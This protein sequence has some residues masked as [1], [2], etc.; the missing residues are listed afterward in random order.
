MT[1]RIC[2]VLN[3]GRKHLAR[4]WCNHHYRRWQK[5]GDVQADTP[6]RGSGSDE[7][8]FLSRLERVPGGCWLWS[9]AT[10]SNGYGVIRVGGPG[11]G[12]LTLAHVWSYEHF[13]APVPVGYEVDHTCHTRDASC[14]GGLGCPHHRCVNPAHLEP[15]THRENAL[16]GVNT[17]LTDEDVQ[18]AWG[19]VLAGSTIKDAA[20]QF[21]VHPT[22][23]GARFRRL[24]SPVRR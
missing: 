8:R 12:R 13:V 18:E 16:R 22:T 5:H 1:D 19:L 9:G 2:S 20:R 15:V 24:N 11:G 6:P 23:L 4:G 14:A 17:K 3:C 21:G 7:S 10:M